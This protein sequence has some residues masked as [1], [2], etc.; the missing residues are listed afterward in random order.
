MIAD[1]GRLLAK[2]FQEGI[3]NNFPRPFDV[4]GDMGCVPR[5]R[6][7]VFCQDGWRPAGIWSPHAALKGYSGLF[8]R[9]N[10]LPRI[11]LEKKMSPG[12]FEFSAK[13][14]RLQGS[15]NQAAMESGSIPF[16]AKR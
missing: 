11:F 10:D 8:N 5:Q 9:D 4:T 13:T 16:S 1:F 15:K 14:Q 2:E 3:L 7:F 12:I 6:F